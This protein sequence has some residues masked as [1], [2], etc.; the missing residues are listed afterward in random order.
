MLY[1]RV[2]ASTKELNS[3]LADE[4]VFII[5]DPFLYEK[6]YVEKADRGNLD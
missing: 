2:P 6:T 1:I 5:A 4:V 3:D